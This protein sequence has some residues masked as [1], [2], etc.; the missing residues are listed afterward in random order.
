MRAQRGIGDVAPVYSQPGVRMRWVVS[1]TLWS[2]LP[3]EDPIPIIQE[4][5]WVS[6]QVWTEDLAP[7]T[8]FRFP[9]RSACSVV[10]ISTTLSNCPR[11]AARA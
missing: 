2:L 7:V 5:G 10:A 6:G 1:T 9:S 3:W 4:A 11:V 8:K